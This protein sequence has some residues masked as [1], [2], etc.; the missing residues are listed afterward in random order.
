MKKSAIGLCVALLIAATVAAGAMAADKPS[1][2]LDWYGFVKLDASYDQ[3][4]TSHGN[5]TMW[6]Q[7]QQTL[8]DDEQFNM[9]HRQTCFGFV[10]N[11]TGYQDVAVTGKVEFDLYG[12]GVAE[13]KTLLLL[14]HA[15]F[16]V[17]SQG[18]KLLAGQTWDIVSPLN[19]PML[20]YSVMWGCGNIGYRRPQVSLWYTGEPNRQTAITLA[21]GFFRTIG[22]DLALSLSLAA[23]GADDGTD[24]GIP[25]F[26]GLLDVEHE[27]ASGGSVRV[28]ASGLWGQLKAESNSGSSETY[29][30]WAAAGHLDVSLPSGV[31]LSGE[32]Y[33]GSNLGK[34][35]GSILN[36][37]RL[38]GLSSVGGWAA[39]WVKPSPEVKLTAGYGMADPDDNDL[40]AND[41]SKNQCIFGNIKYSPV[42][43]VT[44]GLEVSQW[45]TQYV[46]ADKVDNL[47]AQTA[48]VLNF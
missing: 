31:G 7:P 38:D 22:D 39:A 44:L 35:Q 45:E 2:N 1:F 29:E 5:F 25:S 37:S 14:R 28:G 36:T 13:N 47:R 46:G 40:A 3:N 33:T 24:A 32:A 10:A 27:F 8:Q 41:R 34:Y 42:A 11:G 9:T 6:V 30:S 16:T 26:Q 19:A 18:F 21:G 43:Q 23:D 4:L 12:G 48:F 20:N 15:F 17:E